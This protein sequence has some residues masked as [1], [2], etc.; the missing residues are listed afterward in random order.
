MI[1]NLLRKR[2]SYVDSVSIAW[3]LS[4]EFGD[5]HRFGGAGLVLQAFK[6]LAY[7]VAV[8]SDLN[9][10]WEC[11]VDVSSKGTQT[12]RGSRVEH[13]FQGIVV[14]EGGAGS[15]AKC[16]RNMYRVPVVWHLYN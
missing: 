11:D 15:L 7:F 13:D 10:A 14:S 3:S 6:T 9:L 2:I 1:T 12:R 8:D 16:E 4:D 5:V